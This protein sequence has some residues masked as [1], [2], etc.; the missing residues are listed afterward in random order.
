MI[1]IT[2]ADGV[3]TG[4]P[5]TA[6]HPRAPGHRPELCFMASRGARLAAGVC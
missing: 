2:S 6:A 1:Q 3:A 4:L 5:G